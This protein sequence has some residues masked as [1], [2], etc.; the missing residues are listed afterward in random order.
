V[1][2]HGQLYKPRVKKRAARLVG[3]EAFAARAS[4]RS[5]R[6]TVF[7]LDGTTP[8]SQNMSNI[9]QKDFDEFNFSIDEYEE[10]I[11]GMS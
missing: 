2:V 9:K 1:S 3:G 7:F 11:V 8:T 4:P 10:M 6:T 5:Y